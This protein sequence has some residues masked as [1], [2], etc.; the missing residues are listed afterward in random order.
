M[1]RKIKV[2]QHIF[3]TDHPTR[4]YQTEYRP[5][6]QRKIRYRKN[7]A[8]LCEAR[9]FLTH[10]KVEF[11]ELKEWEPAPDGNRRLDDLIDLWFKLHGKNLYDIKKRLAKMKA[12]SKLMG[13]PIA[14]KI[15]ASHWA[16]YRAKR[17]EDVS[18]KT[19]NNDQIYLN[20]MFNELIRLGEISQN[21]ITNVRQLKYKQP[22]MGFL[23]K[24]EI[25]SLLSELKNSSNLD[26]YLVAKICLSTGARWG[27]AESLSKRN[28]KESNVTFINTKGG[29]NRTIPISDFRK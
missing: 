3:K 11:L 27:E 10:K 18:I 7:F 25:D 12:T 28:V 5:E 24:D 13:N 1:L 17:L 19:V 8:T 15:T 20:A 6:G 2:H 21:P 26:A 9:R 23:D 4:P 16:E 22:E 29:L 14:R